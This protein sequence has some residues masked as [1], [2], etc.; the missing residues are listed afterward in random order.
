MDKL[1]K[2]ASNAERFELKDIVAALDEIQVK[3]TALGEE[4]DSRL[5]WT[6]FQEIRADKKK[7]Q[8]QLEDAIR[9][10]QAELADARKR[11]SDENKLCFT[12]L[13]CINVPSFG[14]IATG[15]LILG[16]LLGIFCGCRCD[17]SRLL[18][19]CYC[20]CPARRSANLEAAEDIEI[21]IQDN[22]DVEKEEP[23]LDDTDANGSL[24]DDR[25]DD[26]REKLLQNDSSTKSLPMADDA[27]IN[28]K[29]DSSDG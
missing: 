10:H 4:G 27:G 9:Q 24:D 21:V 6:D 7:L 5:S 3:F 19:C 25:D 16:L 20:C 12:E 18:D 28:N 13:F 11:P 14:G 29:D 15:F 23:A 1:W 17:V 22:D 8:K 2:F 26:K